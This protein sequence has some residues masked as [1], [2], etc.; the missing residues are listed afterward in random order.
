VKKLFELL[1]VTALLILSM[2][3]VAMAVPHPKAVDVS[4][5]VPNSKSVDVSL[6]ASSVIVKAGEAVQLTAVTVKQGSAFTDNWTGA[7]KSSTVISENGTCVSSAEFMASAPGTHVVTYDIV[8]DAGSSGVNFEGTGS[9]TITVVE[10]I[11]VQT[12][13][14]RNI[15]S[16]PKTDLLGNISGYSAIGDIYLIW[17]DGTATNYGKLFF[18]F[19]ATQVTRSLCVTVYAD[20][21]AYSYTVWVTRPI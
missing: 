2:G 10:P 6:A 8:M 11:T 13:E 1:I 3:S 12:V 18:N 14:V 5:A 17:S 7:A 19:S 15:T 20:G 16:V 21:Q 9:I 4:L